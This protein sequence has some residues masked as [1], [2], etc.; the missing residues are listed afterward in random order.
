MIMIKSPYI[1]I[2]LQLLLQFLV[3]FVFC[4]VLA[5]NISPVF[6]RFVV[7]SLGIN[8]SVKLIWY[9]RCN[10]DEDSLC[11]FQCTYKYVYL[12]KFYRKLQLWNCRSWRALKN[13]VI[14]FVTGKYLHGIKLLNHRPSHRAV[15]LHCESKHYAILHLF[16]TLTNVSR[17]QKSFHYWTPLEICNFAFYK[18]LPTAP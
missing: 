18:M 10:F 12:N 17:F 3:C 1:L 4:I 6:Y 16:I 14:S 8:C 15:F 9:R 13:P 11:S 5:D 7:T 2:T